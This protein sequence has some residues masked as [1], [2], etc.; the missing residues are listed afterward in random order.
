MSVPGESSHFIMAPEARMKALN[1][2]KIEERSPRN[3]AVM[4]FFLPKEYHN[5]SCT[6]FTTRIR[7]STFGAD[8]IAGR[9]SRDV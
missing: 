1:H 3:A 5:S 6:D 2:L 8:C 4:M 7:R 9:K